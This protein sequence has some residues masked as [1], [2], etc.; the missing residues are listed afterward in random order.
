LRK[1]VRMEE[2]M[3]HDDPIPNRA[4]YDTVGIT[5]KNSLV[6]GILVVVAIVALLVAGTQF[7]SPLP[8]TTRTA[9]NS[10]MK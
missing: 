10:A 2:N 8:M 1:R 3:R 7:V 4:V 5:A 9:G 6:S